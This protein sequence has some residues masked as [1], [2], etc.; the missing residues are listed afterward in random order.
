MRLAYPVMAL[1][2]GTYCVVAKRVYYSATGPMI[3]GPLVVIAGVALF[4]FGVWGAI[5]TLREFR[6]EAEAPRSGSVDEK[7]DP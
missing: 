6:R 5:G 2:F 4:L 1:A 3:E 7:S